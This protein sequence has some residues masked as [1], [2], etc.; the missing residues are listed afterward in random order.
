L[1]GSH[2]PLTHFASASTT[3]RPAFA[4]DPAH[5][6]EAAKSDSKRTRKMEEA[7]LFDVASWDTRSSIIPI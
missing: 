4:D 6:G 2:R 3:T 5:E 1:E 7:R